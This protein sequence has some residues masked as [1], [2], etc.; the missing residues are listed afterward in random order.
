[1]EVEILLLNPVR[2][3]NPDRVEKDCSVEQEQWLLKSSIALLHK[4][5]KAPV[6]QLML[7]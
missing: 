4:T 2:V 6:L 5:K 3:L 1:M 7:F